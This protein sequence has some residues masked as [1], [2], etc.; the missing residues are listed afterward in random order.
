MA[1]EILFVA[2][3]GKQYWQAIRWYV[4]CLFTHTPLADLNPETS[5]ENA[6]SFF[7]YS[8]KEEHMEPE[9]I[10]GRGRGPFP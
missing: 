1:V 8:H 9:W 2:E 3:T 10:V 7:Y 5:M 4:G 6:Q